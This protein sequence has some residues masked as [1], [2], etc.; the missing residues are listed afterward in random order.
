M[1]NAARNPP[2]RPI[3]I[4]PIGAKP[5]IAEPTDNIVLGPNP[6]SLYEA[7]RDANIRALTRELTDSTY[8]PEQTFSV[9][10]TPPAGGDP[11]STDL[12]PLQYAAL[13]G[14]KGTVR[15]L[16]NNST[17]DLSKTINGLSLKE[18]VTTYRKDDFDKNE[19]RYIFDIVEAALRDAMDDFTSGVDKDSKY[20]KS[21][22]GEINKKLSKK[23][24]DR[25]YDD[26]KSPK[27]LPPTAPKPT[28]TLV[29]DAKKAGTEDGSKDVPKNPIYLA[30]AVPPKTPQEQEAYGKAYDK[31]LATY[32][33]E[34]DAK[35]NEP[36]DVGKL[37]SQFST[38]Y[39]DAA[40]QSEVEKIYN[41]THE[42]NRSKTSDLV[43]EAGYV[44]TYPPSE[45]LLS[46]NFFG[47]GSELSKIVG[48]ST[49][50]TTPKTDTDAK[51]KEGLV[52]FVKNLQSIIGQAKYAGY[53][54]GRKKNAKYT[55]PG[56]ISVG[57]KEYAID[58]GKLNTR[59]T[60]LPSVDLAVNSDFTAASELLDYLRTMRDNADRTLEGMIGYLRVQSETNDNPK[61][62]QIL[63]TIVVSQKGGTI[64][65]LE[66][67]KLVRR[68][69][70]ITDEDIRN[71]FLRRLNETTTDSLFNSIKSQVESAIQL[72]SQL[73]RREQ[74]QQWMTLAQQEAEQ[75]L[76]AE[77]EPVAEQQPPLE[78]ATQPET[79][80]LSE[81]QRLSSERT[82]QDAQNIINQIT[83]QT[84]KQGF[85]D[86]LNL[87][88]A[89]S[90]D[91]IEIRNQAR[92]AVQSQTEEPLAP[93][94]PGLLSRTLAKASE[95]G[96]SAATAARSGIESVSTV[97]STGAQTVGATPSV[98]GKYIVTGL[99]S[100]ST[101]S[102]L[103]NL[104]QQ[105]LSSIPKYQTTKLKS[106]PSGISPDDPSLGTDVHPIQRVQA[107]YDKEFE[108]GYKEAVRPMG[109]T[110]RKSKKSNRITKKKQ[111]SKK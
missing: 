6:P 106:P 35:L 76:E 78:V 54:D 87:P 104:V 95:L 58:F 84:I 62:K 66:K 68:V 33:G 88:T 96:T 63:K 4:D 36:A 77:E 109:G 12:T 9:T 2:S 102:Q 50:G 74:R 30:T 20:G 25:E 5:R 70:G 73:E 75:R 24:Y 79:Q 29:E 56:K 101:K 22:D 100:V 90:D 82:K 32:Y 11:I 19:I 28:S 1:A 57:Q 110:R 71:D 94:E 47:F 15:Y 61:I 52:E 111:I 18:A 83:D 31:A 67:A 72:Q 21:L 3:G 108:R 49:S 85:L 97:V 23:I 48:F 7:I 91:Y 53:T 26:L 42:K 37:S 16:I 14:L 27:P 43:K 8:N 13:K 40:H 98:V 45:T 64:N 41:E 81:E 10:I 59:I 34:R 65:P 92:L 39:T 51:Y 105:A 60:D 99:G 103:Y 44:G 107:M 55:T 89:T 17:P 69:S 80:R 46:G 86:R 93:S 38:N